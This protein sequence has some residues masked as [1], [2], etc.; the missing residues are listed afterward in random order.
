VQVD[1]Q[2][3][4]IDA[5]PDFRSQA[6]AAGLQRLDAVLLTHSHYDHVAGL[7]D[8]RPLIEKG[9]AMPIYGDNRTLS[10]VRERF[11]YA[12]VVSSEGSTRPEMELIPIDGTFCIG[13]TTITPIPI[14]HG[15][16]TITCY[17]IGNLGYVTD[18]STIAPASMEQLRGLDV[19]VLN[20]LRYKPYPT[21]FSLT[22]ALE[23]IADLRPRRAFLVHMNHHI[24]HAI[25]T[26]HLPPGVA[27]A[28]DGLR[29]DI[30]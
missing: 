3:L 28:Y 27:L 24:D 7:D 25:V 12:F 20:A 2:N 9:S 15:T 21:H 14:R 30:S 19:L 11:S 16:W 8:L 5:G 10:D 1:G 29:V 22:E 17:R 23:V 4:L 13:P 6:L 18:A 26:A